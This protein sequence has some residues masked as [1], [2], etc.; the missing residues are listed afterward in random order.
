MANYERI[1]NVKVSMEASWHM[2]LSS[3]W[4]FQ[5]SKIELKKDPKSF[6]KSHSMFSDTNLL[7]AEEKYNNDYFI[8][9]N[10]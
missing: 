7:Y 4:N 9:N 2:L 5:K 3:F 6:S 8:L 1:S 10:E